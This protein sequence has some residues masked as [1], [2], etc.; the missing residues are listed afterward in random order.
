[1]DDHV[2]RPHEDDQVS[3]RED[4]MGGGQR[5][6]V[7]QH[8]QH[9]VA[10]LDVTATG[11]LDRRDVGGVDHICLHECFGANRHPVVQQ[12]RHDV[13]AQPDR[14]H[15]HPHEVQVLEREPNQHGEAH[16]HQE[17]GAATVR[18][19]RQC[20]ADHTDGEQRG[21]VHAGAGESSAPGG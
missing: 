19:G 2:D 9:V 5:D 4:L 15:A 17:R 16:E 18:T 11:Q 7:R 10:L 12:D 21:F 13:G 20:L 14:H 3:E 8:R 1:M 6:D